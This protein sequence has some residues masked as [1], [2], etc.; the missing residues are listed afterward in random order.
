LTAHRSL[1]I[2]IACALALITGSCVRADDRTDDEPPTFTVLYPGDERVLG[3]EGR[4][5]YRPAQFL[6]FE[7]LIT[8][9]AEGELE[10][11]LARDWE[12]SPDYRTWT[13]RL[14]TDARWHDGE[15]VTARDVKFTFDLLTHPDVLVET[16]DALDVTALDDSTIT[17]T[18]DRRGTYSIADEAVV[19]N[20]VYPEH[21]LRDLDLKQFW[22]W[23]F[24]TRPIGSG[25]FRY[26]GH[27]PR[28]SIELQANPDHFLGKPRIDR[29]VLKFGGSSLTELLAGAV[30]AVAYVDRTEVLTLA[31]DPR[32]RVYQNVY[33]TSVQA[34]VWNHRHDALGDRAVRR[35]LTH[36]IDRQVV[37][38]AVDLPDGLPLAD[39]IH[40]AR[41]FRLGD[42]PPPL[43]YDPAGAKELLARAGW[44]DTDA[45]GVRSKLGKPLRFTLLT[46]EGLGRRA[47]VVIQQQLGD[48][49]V[50][51]EILTLQNVVERVRAG[52]FDAAILPVFPAG[53]L[54]H[55]V[56]FGDESV[57]G[58]HNPTVSRLLSEAETTL[59]PVELDRIYAELMPIFLDDQPMTVLFPEVRTTVAHRSV[60]GLSSPYGAEP[61]WHAGELWLQDD[62]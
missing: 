1:I 58:Y 14:R 51:M 6:V 41:Q 11:R 42:V 55:S 33:P 34:I 5:Y 2:G 38:Q 23:D 39:V 47:A 48:V 16:P 44:V 7:P 50:K 27:V 43:P 17:I 30:D 31:G 21:L 29:V 32:Y 37:H 40:T 24:W 22:D 56:Y 59:S 18:R 62:E 61:T 9:N 35:A 4:A 3:A 57:L 52:D 8:W 26:V 54:S 25:P 12:H 13:I 46:F 19:Y 15:P 49:G 10:P 60:R 28:T 20:A 45:D 53:G 36:A